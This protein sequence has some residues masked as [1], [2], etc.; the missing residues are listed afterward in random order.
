TPTPSRLAPGAMPPGVPLYGPETDFEQQ[1]RS[2]GVLHLHGLWQAHTR[3]GSRV[4]RAGRIPYVIT[5]HGMVDPWALGQKAWKKRIYLAV[6]EGK[7]RRGA[8]CLHA[9]SRPE[10]GHLRAIAP[11]TPI[12]FIPNGVDL[13]FASDLPSRSILEAERPELRGKFVLL[14]FS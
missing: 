9:L 6:M 7:N 8:S 13:E 10:I 2:A 5:A 11:R 12:A 3:R 4:A 14:F 1:A